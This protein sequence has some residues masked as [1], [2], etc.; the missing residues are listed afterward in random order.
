MERKGVTVKEAAKILGCCEKT[1]RNE[2]D[3][4]TMKTYRVG[5]RGIRIPLSV[6]V[7][8][9]GEKEVRV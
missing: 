5:K 1:V 4:G 2:I 6:L 7:K 3:N 9:T 8:R